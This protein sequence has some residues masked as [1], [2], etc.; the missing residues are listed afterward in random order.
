MSFTL[1]VFITI[2]LASLAMADILTWLGVGLGVSIPTAVA[3]ALSG[4]GIIIEMRKQSNKYGETKQELVK[5]QKFMEKTSLSQIHEKIAMLNNYLSEIP[6]PSKNIADYKSKKIVSDVRAVSEIKDILT[7]Q[8]KEELRI[9]RD[10]L[11]EQ[12]TSKDYDVGEIKVVFE[13][14]FSP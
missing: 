5:L 4:L 1:I 14:L 13:E 8:Q 11:I 9:V 6:W 3:I 7:G 2:S 10:K 12:M